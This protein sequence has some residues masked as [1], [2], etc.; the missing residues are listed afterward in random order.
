MTFNDILNERTQYELKD[1]VNKDKTLQLDKIIKQTK[2]YAMSK[3]AI[4][5]FFNPILKKL[6]KVEDENSF[7]KLSKGESVFFVPVVELKALSRRIE[8]EIQQGNYNNNVPLWMRFE[9][10]IE[11]KYAAKSS[12]ENPSEKMTK[13]ERGM[14]FDG[15]V[16]EMIAGLMGGSS[17]TDYLLSND[18]VDFFKADIKLKTKPV[19]LNNVKVD[20]EDGKTESFSKRHSFIEVKRTDGDAVLGQILSIRTEPQ[21]NEF[22]EKLSKAIKKKYGFDVKDKNKVAKFF[23]EKTYKEL[24]NATK[25]KKEAILNRVYTHFSPKG[26]TAFIS[27]GT[28]TDNE[29]TVPIKKEY[30]K[31]YFEEGGQWKPYS[32]CPVSIS[33]MNIKAKIIKD[34]D[35]VVVENKLLDFT[36][37]LLSV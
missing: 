14:T 25:Q 27:I 2:D 30:V 3:K 18:K 7:V 24:K 13:K 23:F 6:D 4:N 32:S 11:N 33:R 29:K 17:Y 34:Y 21:W 28:T 31:L 35:G 19:K 5:N 26:G 8:N 36:K 15:K 37:E 16:D 12:Q 10:D 22:A 9:R 20:K 1:F